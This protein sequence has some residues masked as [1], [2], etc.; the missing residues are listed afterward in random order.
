M[1]GIPALRIKGFYLAITT[2]AAQ[3]IFPLIYHAHAEFLVRRGHRP[4]PG[5]GP[6]RFPG[7]RY[8]HLPVLPS[9]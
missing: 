3:V 1:F 2:I 6:D 9:S 7:V 4:E 5:T 8:G